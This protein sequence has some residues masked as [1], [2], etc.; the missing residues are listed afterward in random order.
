MKCKR[1]IVWHSKFSRT[2]NRN[3]MTT[4]RHRILGFWSRNQWYMLFFTQSCPL[5]YSTKKV[6]FP[7]L[8]LKFLGVILN[9][10]LTL[11]WGLKCNILQWWKLSI[12]FSKWNFSN[13]IKG[14]F[15]P[16]FFSVYML[17]PLSML[18]NVNSTSQYSLFLK[19]YNKQSMLVTT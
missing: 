3:T 19:S 14:K 8:F 15:C 13:L 6:T 4:R 12:S 1:I 17:A 9:V 18:I 16:F 5:A 7:F 11:F 2:L 10:N